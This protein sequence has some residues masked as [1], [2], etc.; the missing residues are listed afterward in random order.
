MLH[1]SESSL[2]FLEVPGIIASPSEDKE[3]AFT[4]E[5]VLGCRVL[6]L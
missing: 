1:F 2:Q 5:G 6:P 3:G 4:S